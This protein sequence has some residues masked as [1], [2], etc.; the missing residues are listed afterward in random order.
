L[1]LKR[2]LWG[3]LLARVT[4]ILPAHRDD[5]SELAA[6]HM[7]ASSGNG[8][9]PS[10]QALCRII[11]RGLLTRSALRSERVPSVLLVRVVGMV[12]RNQLCYSL[13]AG[14]LEPDRQQALLCSKRKRQFP[15]ILVG[16]FALI[17]SAT[18]LVQMLAVFQDRTVSFGGAYA[19]LVFV[20]TRARLRNILYPTGNF[21][22]RWRS[23]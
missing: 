8:R 6:C 11:A 14:L 1:V 19:S 5:G 22:R 15:V 2:K 10:A 9:S 3:A 18:R 17:P 12:L 20:Q 13:I 16:T 4:F 23:V 21:G 7:A